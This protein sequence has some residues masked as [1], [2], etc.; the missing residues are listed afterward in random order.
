MKWLGYL[1]V[2]LVSSG[3]T[4]FLFTREKIVGP[5]RRIDPPVLDLAYSDFVSILLT[6]LAVLLTAIAIGVGVVAIWTIR[7][8]RRDVRKVAR[9]NVEQEM[10]G[11]PERIGEAVERQLQDAIEKAGRT[12]RLDDALQRA[13]AVI[14]FGGPQTSRELQPGYD[15]TG[16]EENDNA[17]T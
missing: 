3:I 9:E 1:F 6:A 15:E 4:A 12:G 16:E 8:I 7:E 14:T 5:A 2:A 17:I 13:L 11:V 10:Q